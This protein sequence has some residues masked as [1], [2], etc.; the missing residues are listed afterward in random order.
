MS[1]RVCTRCKVV[2]AFISMHCE[3]LQDVTSLT[4]REILP[5]PFRWN[6]FSGFFKT[7]LIHAHTH[8]HKYYMSAITK[9]QD[10]MPSDIDFMSQM[11]ELQKWAFG[12]TS[13]TSCLSISPT[14]SLINTLN[15]TTFF[16]CSA[17]QF[18]FSHPRWWHFSKWTRLVTLLSHQLNHSLFST[19]RTFTNTVKTF[20]WTTVIVSVNRHSIDWSSVT[21]GTGGSVPSFN[22]FKWDFSVV[23][24]L[25]HR[26]FDRPAAWLVTRHILHLKSCRSRSV[27]MLCPLSCFCF[28]HSQFLLFR[29]QVEAR[30]TVE[31]ARGDQASL[32]LIEI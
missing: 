32:C 29:F 18:C 27:N 2:F 5:A 26:P 3:A 8:T 11:V 9:C 22:L 16:H 25:H 21:A 24:L 10:N 23:N 28:S 14:Q 13:K 12:L 20:H 4:P 17:G 6:L 31:H 19:I 15:H 30:E 1:H 7:F